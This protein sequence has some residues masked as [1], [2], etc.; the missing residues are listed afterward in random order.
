M[1]SRHLDQADLL[2]REAYEA[3]LCE[4]DPRGLVEVI[5]M[6]APVCERVF[7]G[8]RAGPQ[9]L[10]APAV[11]QRVVRE[12]E[13]D[14]EFRRILIGMWEY[15]NGGLLDYLD[16]LTVGQIEQNV[17]M[18]TR[19]FGGVNLY[20]GLALDERKG[21]NKLLRRYSKNLLAPE[22]REE[23]PDRPAET[24]APQPETRP[25]Q[26][27]DLAA[28]KNAVAHLKKEKRKLEQEIGSLKKSLQREQKRSGELQTKLEEAARARDDALR[29]AG[30]ADHER[31][32]AEKRAGEQESR[33]RDLR[34]AL[35]EAKPAP[36]RSSEPTAPWQEAVEQLISSGRAEAAA[37][38]LAALAARSADDQR[39]LELLARAYRACGRRDD[40][41][42]ILLQLVTL[43]ARRG[44]LGPA[45]NALCRVLVLDS[46]SYEAAA[47]LRGLFGRV[48]ARNEKRVSEIR[49]ELT[50][51]RR[52]S[53]EIYDAVVEIARGVSQ[54]LAEALQSLPHEVQPD[55]LLELKND[56]QVRHISPRQ[57]AQA[58][59]ANDLATIR[60]VRDALRSSPELRKAV[61]EAVVSIDPTC[62]LPLV[63][64]TRPV[65]VDGSNAAYALPC[66]DGKPR[67]RNIT[68]LVRELRRKCYFPVYVCAD[69][70]L[71]YQID[72]PSDLQALVDSGSV[73][74]SES[75]T[76]ADEMIVARAQRLDCP[77]ATNDRM[78]DWD[79]EGRV[80]KIRFDLERESA[81][82][83]DVDA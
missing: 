58:V 26:A 15:D 37:E 56:N 75:G 31:V 66:S 42:H 29:R 23:A 74:L 3:F 82:I 18:L 54:D 65:V 67:L 14:A 41:C 2:P 48:S 44:S 45:L 68:N 78:L 49:R 39:P 6:A 61:E 1:R 27:A 73:E 64:S 17:T 81:D 25:K 51:L 19:K 13:G 24:P 35:D 11:R 70:A 32:E 10:K 80:P 46:R 69:A 47:E 40:E 79:P 60:F 5:K 83:I 20:L 76:D 36:T 77:V 53:V 72:R 12:M 21:V 8:F 28:T 43:R 59:E 7:Q 16:T 55:R 50:R 57:M 34:R 52:A 4:R 9:A 71:P 22:P 30:R 33:V 38:F 63:T 62:R